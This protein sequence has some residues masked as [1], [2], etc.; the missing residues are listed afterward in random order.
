M[1]CNVVVYS[2]NRV[3]PRKDNAYQ[4]VRKFDRGRIVAYQEC[5]LSFRDTT[6]KNGRNPITVMSHVNMEPMGCWGHTERYVGSQR[7]HMTNAREDRLLWGRP[8]KIVQS[9]HRPFTQKMGNLQRGQYLHVRCNDVWSSMDCQ[10][11]DHYCG[12]SWKCK[13]DRGGDSGA[14][15]DKAGCKSDT[16]SSF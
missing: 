13:K 5:E 7:P 15:N 12:F 10:N 11:G 2:K 6:F 9:H 4:Q 14:P 1:F 8:S 3:L 16:T